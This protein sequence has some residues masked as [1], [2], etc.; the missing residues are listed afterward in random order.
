MG[1]WEGQLSLSRL[2][3]GGSVHGAVCAQHPVLLESGVV[4]N[5]THAH[6]YTAAEK[7]PT[8][9]DAFVPGGEGIEETCSAR[10]SFEQ[11]N[12]MGALEGAAEQ[13]WAAA[14][15]WKLRGQRA[16]TP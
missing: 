6:I 16:H 11:R 3:H 1:L 7:H 13:L 15:S 4:P 5:L 8:P 14:T 9:C 10:V 2:T 12:P